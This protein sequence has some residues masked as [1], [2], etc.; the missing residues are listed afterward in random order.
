MQKTRIREHEQG[1][2]EAGF[3]VQFDPLVNLRV[4]L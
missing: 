3:K 1:Q 4:F 2:C